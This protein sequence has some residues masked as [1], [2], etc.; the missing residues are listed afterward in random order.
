MDDMKRAIYMLALEKIS[1]GKERW[2]CIALEKAAA[3][4]LGYEDNLSSQEILEELLPEF[5]QLYDGVCWY[6]LRSDNSV[7]FA[8]EPEVRRHNGPWWQ[9]AWKAPRTRI[10]NYLLTCK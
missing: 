7:I 4:V 2:V 9:Y 5:S 8:S 3:E 1:N 10:L 6:K